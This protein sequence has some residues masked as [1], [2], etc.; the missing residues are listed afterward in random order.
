MS[1]RDKAF[2]AAGE[3]LKGITHRV[4]S[5]GLRRRDGARAA[6][7][8]CSTER[9]SREGWITTLPR[10]LRR[11]ADFVGHQEKFKLLQ[12]PRR[13]GCV[14]FADF[15]ELIERKVFQKL[16]AARRRP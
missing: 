7:R 13:R 8:S 11:P 10:P 5:E 1:L 6:R 12:W 14:V 16:N 15:V 2:G 4:R 9:G 3:F